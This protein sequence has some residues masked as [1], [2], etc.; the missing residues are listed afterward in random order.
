MPY[1]R[2]VADSGASVS[3]AA[4][5]ICDGCHSPGGSYDGVNDAT[6]G[7]KNNWSISASSAS[8][9]YNGAAFQTGKEKWCA[10]CHDESASTISTIPAPNVIG[11]EDNSGGD[12]IYGPWGFYKSGHGLPTSFTYDYSGGVTSGADLE[13]LDCHSSTVDHVDGDARTHD[14][15]DSCDSA[16]YRTSYRLLQVGGNEPMEIPWTGLGSSDA[17]KFRLCVQGG[18]HDSTPYTTQSAGLNTNFYTTGADG[19]KNRHEYHLSL[20]NQNRYYADYNFGGTLNSRLICVTCHNVHG[21]ARLAMVRDGKLINREPGQLI[22]YKNDA[23]TYYPIGPP[24]DDPPVPDDL[25][26]AASDGTV[27]RGGSS[28]N[29]CSHCHASNNLSNEDRTPYQDVSQ[30][31]TL[32]WTGETYYVADGSNPDSAPAE[33]NFKFRVEYTDTNN[34][35]PVFRELWIDRNDDLDFGDSQEKISMDDAVVF[36]VN[37]T[38]GKIYTKTISLTKAGDNT[39]N[40]RFYASDGEVAT[41]PPTS[42][43][44]VTLTNNVPTFAWLGELYYE[45]DGVYPDNGGSGSSF[46]FKVSYTDIDDEAPTSIQVWLDADHSGTYEP[47]EKNDMTAIDGGDTDYTDGKSYQKALNITYSGDGI[48]NYRFY[49]SDGTDGATGDPAYDSIVTVT[50]TANSVPSLDWVTATCRDKGVKPDS[51]PDGGDFEFYIRYTD[52]DDQCPP[53]ASDIQVWIDEDD[54]SSYEG[55]EQ[56]NL[57]EVDGGDTDCS[58]GKLYKVTKQLSLA[59]DNSITY[60]FYASD[61]TDTAVGNPVSDN[62]L[63]VADALK[64]RT[65]GGT[66]WY[67]TIQSAVDAVN[68]AHTVLVYEGTYTEDVLFDGTDDASTTVRSVCG[69]DTTIIS[70]T[71]AA[72]KFQNNSGNTIDGFQLQD[73]TYGAWLNA[74]TGTVANCKIHNISGSG[75]T[76]SNA[77]S[78]AIIT[79]TEIYSNTTSYG[80]GVYFND[81]SGHTITD[82]IIRNNT[83][84]IHGGGLFV[85]NTDLIIT[86]SVIRDNTTAGSGGGIYANSGDIDLIRSSMTGNTATSG[87]GGGVHQS[88]AG[89]PLYI[90]NSIIA[91]NTA[92][93]AG[94]IYNNASTLNI[95]N[96]T[97]ADN[98]STTGNSGAIYNQNATTTIRN[99]ILWDNVAATDGHI[100]YTN[101][102]SVTISDS[103]IPNDGDGMFDNLPYFDG[104]VTPTISG[105]TTDFDPEFVGGGD[106][107][108][109]SIS[110]AIDNASATY[111]PDNDID[112]DNRP[113]GSA[114]DI[115]ADEYAVALPGVS[116]TSASQLSS[117]ESGTLTITA[118]LSAASS[119]NVTVPFIVSGSSTATGGGTD[120]SITSSPITITAGN[121][122]ADITITI[123]TDSLD[124]VNETVITVMGDPTNASKGTT[125]THTAS[126]LDDD[127][128]PSVT[129]TSASQSTANE[130]GTA[131]ITAQLSAVS[132]RDVTVPFTVN[133]SSTATGGGTDYSI[134]SSPITI[135]EGS[136]T[137][138]I[139][140]TIATDSSDEN[141]ETVI[142]DMGTPV[143][144]SQ[145]ATTTH[146]VTI[147][148][149]DA[150]PTVS[151][152]SASQA[153]ADESGTATI[154]AQLSVVSGK[155]I[156]V[157]F[158]VNGSSTAT[159]GGTDYSITSS[160]ITITAGNASEDITVTIT[161]DPD[162]E[163][164]ET[165]IVDMGTPTNASQGATTTHTLTITDDDAVVNA[166]PTLVWYADDCRTEGARPALGDGGA[167]FEFW[168]EYTDDDNDAPTSIQVWIDEDDDATYQ[169]DEKYDLTETDGG[170]TTYTDGKYYKVTRAVAAA[171]DGTLNYRFYAS[172]GSDPASGTAATGSTVE[173]LSATV[174]RP[175]GT[176]LPNDYT[177]IISA[178]NAVSGNILVYPNDDFTSATYSEAL[179]MYNKDNRTVRS[180]CGADY[181]IV[182]STSTTVTVQDS[183]NFVLD[184]FSITGSTSSDGINVNRVDSTTFTLRNSKVYGNNDGIYINDADDVPVLIDNVEIYNNSVRGITTVNS[185]DDVNIVN[186]EIHSHNVSSTGAAIS[187]N[188][189]ATVTISKSVIRDNVSSTEGGAIY[190]NLGSLSIENSIFADNQGTNGGV[191]R[192]NSGPTVSIINSTFADNQATNGG[193]MYICTTGS[194][195][196]RNSV[197]WNNTATTGNVIYK[198]CGSGNIGTISHTDISSSEIYNATFTDGGGNMDPAQNPLFVNAGADNYHIQSG[199]PVVDQASAT[200]APADDIDGESRPLGSADDM[201]A[202]EKE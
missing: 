177:S 173:V 153:T 199:S 104:N 119:D 151:F 144:A 121:T 94:A 147:T 133:G 69:A 32:D 106:Y 158:T 140:V 166:A 8:K 170:D 50:S 168:V 76:T 175:S 78:S 196:I 189:G 5:D 44:T 185:D 146:T 49:A 157:P 192:T 19:Y 46:T 12:G 176:S 124:E 34:D 202:D 114:D 56:Y 180:T 14:C 200:Y 66:G 81:G 191:I 107:H 161:T 190:V 165:V 64:V 16:E 152:T 63:T 136:T 53:T 3:L 82:S 100:I 74:A 80:P 179:T 45:A 10:T 62:S 122:T 72:V 77:A 138:D 2:T 1:F 141:N 38:N 91:D 65:A 139:T 90:E 88:N 59:G 93:Q 29:L 108:I 123:A 164:D 73:G 113:I 103:V 162:I 143:G 97:V 23:I 193:I 145:G 184:G 154:T 26:L 25:P 84:T 60:R 117:A 28:A 197:F 51:G 125:T 40:Y 187:I 160:P 182:S 86:D 9:I 156:T 68:G 24:T 109:Q 92:T 183:A 48:F 47:G 127:A 57:T 116:F 171:G 17:T 89:S 41:G 35:S 198:A 126:I 135:T 15:S 95:I 148:D 87:T 134:T 30:A 11:D 71:G 101:S 194:T 52:P 85:Q 70:S 188:N 96:S 155:T 83:S 13:C 75:V 67:S 79:G 129:F 37:Y 4:T 163:P 20:S 55:G 27:W 39:L 58:D 36:D 120:Y 110:S 61:G 132:G 115:G 167:D 43:K 22:Y 33:S 186:S 7:A 131:T 195:T 31:P 128:S 174:V 172:D 142:V 137:A 112:G 130:T 54:S 99:S 111:A 118:E 181:T 42:E 98:E 178:I 6:V 149:D 159:G 21:S 169:G 102:G 201:G 18:C 105:F 150:E